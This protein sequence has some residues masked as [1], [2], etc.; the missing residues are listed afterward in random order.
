MHAVVRMVVLCCITLPVIGT[1][2]GCSGD[3]DK[4]PKIRTIKGVAKSVDAANNQVSMLFKNDKGM[5]IVLKGYVQAD[6]EVWINGKIHKLE[7]VREGDTVSVT[8]YRDKSSEEPK[9]IATKIEVTRAE[10]GDWKKQDKPADSASA[11]TPN[12]ATPAK[13]Q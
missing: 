8:G 9:L 4:G 5:E 1:V 12:T 11:A 2:S 7:D 3:R 10:S 13:A 6:T